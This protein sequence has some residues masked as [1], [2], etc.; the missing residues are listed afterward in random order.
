MKYRIEHLFDLLINKA[1]DL[2]PVYL[3]KDHRVVALI[4]LLS[5][6]LRASVLIE[7]S[8]R[9][10]LKATDQQLSGVYAGNKRRKTQ[11]PTIS[12]LLRAFR[13][14]SVAFYEQNQQITT[15][16][17]TALSNTQSH[18]LKLLNLSELYERLLLLLKPQ[19]VLCET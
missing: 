15:V 16:E 14:M 9:E 17:M 11:A 10:A 8:V 7:N 5:I 3:H 13:G 18:I 4:R 1:V 6:A 19:T 2:L 12:I